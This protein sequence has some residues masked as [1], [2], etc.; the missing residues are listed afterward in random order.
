MFRVAAQ[1]RSPY[2]PRTGSDSEWASSRVPGFPRRPGEIPMRGGALPSRAGWARIQ[3][4]KATA[5]CSSSGGSQRLVSGKGSETMLCILTRLNEYKWGIDSP[6][7]EPPERV[8]A[9][10]VP[11]YH[12][13]LVPPRLLR[14]PPSAAT[15]TTGTPGH[16][17][18][19]GQAYG[20]QHTTGRKRPA[21][22][23]DVWGTV[24]A[25]PCTAP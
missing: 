19:E 14:R 11:S 13:R 12:Q 8:R 5:A 10:A 1:S 9:Q 17:G 21:F 24:K 2:Y 3:V 23:G 15:V 22:C 7:S 6:R 20:P 18:M 25:G 4:Q 16:A